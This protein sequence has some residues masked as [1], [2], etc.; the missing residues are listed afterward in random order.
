MFSAFALLNEIEFLKAQIR[1]VEDERAEYDRALHLLRER[2]N[3]LL[4]EYEELLQHVRQV[5]E[6][7]I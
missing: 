7:N 1:I 4:E 5:T 6:D 2:L 3:F